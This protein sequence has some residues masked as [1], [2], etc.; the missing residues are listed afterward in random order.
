MIAQSV[1]E[2]K[3]RR[4]KEERIGQRDE[5]RKRDQDEEG[6]ESAEVSGKDGK[7]R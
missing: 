7:R 3:E 1:T 6:G 4:V 5:R 2:G